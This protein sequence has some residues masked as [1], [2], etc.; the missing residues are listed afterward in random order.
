D[1]RLLL[2][3]LDG[4]RQPARRRGERAG[5]P[6]V[7]GARGVVG[8]VEVEDE[9]AALRAEVGALDRV[10]QVAAAAVGRSPACRGAERQ[11]EPAAVGLEPEELE[12]VPGEANDGE[13]G[14]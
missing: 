8:E 7:V 5:P 2:T 12:L 3:R 14:R 1:L 4:H 10:E 13:P 9:P 6:R 11:E